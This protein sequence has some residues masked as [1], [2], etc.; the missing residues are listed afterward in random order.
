MPGART[1]AT[2]MHPR[3]Y[4]THHVLVPELLAR[5][6]AVW[7]QTTRSP[8]NDLTLLHEQALLDMA[9]GQVFLRDNGFDHVITVG[10]S[11]GGTLAALYHQQAS[12]APADRIARTPTGRAVDLAG[13]SMPVPDAAV[14][15]APHPGQGA[16]MQRVIDPSVTDEA[17]RYRSTRT[18]TPTGRPTGSPIP[19]PARRTPPTSS[20]V[21]GGPN[22]HGCVASMSAQWNWPTK[23]TERERCSRPVLTPPT[24]AAPWHRG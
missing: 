19:R 8:N 4:F 24:V 21:T 11:G 16:L 3:Q 12:R 7:T 15:M 9:A 18:L 13:S 22:K 2:L 5:G 6:V 10:H 1:V 20:R 17:T 14:F 23:P